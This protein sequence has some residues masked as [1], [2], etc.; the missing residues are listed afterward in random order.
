MR[1]LA[2][3]DQEMGLDEESEEEKPKVDSDQEEEDE[4]IVEQKAT[5]SE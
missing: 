1:V 2:Q 3:S 5:D 4:Q